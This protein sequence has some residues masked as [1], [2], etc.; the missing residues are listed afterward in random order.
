MPSPRTLPTSLRS[1]SRIEAIELPSRGFTAAATTLVRTLDESRSVSLDAAGV[2]TTG[3]GVLRLSIV[4]AYGR[5]L[6]ARADLVLRSEDTGHVQH[7]ATVDVSRRVIIRGLSD[8][9]DNRSVLDVTIPHYRLVRWVVRAV[10]WKEDTITEIAVPIDPEEV[11]APKF[12]A[13]K[14]LPA[15]PRQLCDPLAPG[16]ASAI[17]VYRSMTAVQKA[18]LLNCVARAATLPI[19]EGFTLAQL[20]ESSGARLIDLR[21]DRLRLRLSHDA[22]AQLPL[23]SENS[24]LV[25]VPAALHTPP[26]GYALVASGKTPDPLLRFQLT[27]FRSDADHQVE[28]EFDESQGLLCVFRVERTDYSGQ[29]HPYDVHELLIRHQHVDPGYILG[30]SA[31]AFG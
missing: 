7:F 11:R 12:P 23:S 8:R 3:S 31:R 27:L 18:H 10:P 17:A 19:R 9:V 25:R 26:P 20:L 15:L 13:F 6:N 2:S 16:R 30:T 1:F 24:L 22:A 29:T 5:A 28:L 21:Q 14:D 4:D